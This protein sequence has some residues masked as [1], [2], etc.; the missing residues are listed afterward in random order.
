MAGTLIEEFKTGAWKMV[1]NGANVNKGIIVDINPTAPNPGVGGVTRDP[2]IPS[3]GPP[4]FARLNPN[5]KPGDPGHK[6]VTV[7][8]QWENA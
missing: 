4:F 6:P 8:I 7:W 2:T 1:A 5:T 3:G